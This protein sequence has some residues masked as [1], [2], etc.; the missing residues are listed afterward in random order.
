MDIII[1]SPINKNEY[2]LYYQFR[3][4]T[5]RK[6]LLQPKGSE[7]DE[8]ER[9]SYH[10][11]MLIDNKV[12][13]VGR[14]HFIIKNSIKKAQIRY[15]AIDKNLQRK[16]YGSLI[17]SELEKIAKKNNVGNIFLHARDKAVKFYIKNNYKKTKKAHL[18][19]NSIQHW[20]MDKKI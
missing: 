18:L 5:L 15:M 9:N 11:M 12:I 6:P 17:L 16:G 20:L 7:K 10:I 4:E 14:I 13:G 2:K 8:L 19:F 1:K 3:W